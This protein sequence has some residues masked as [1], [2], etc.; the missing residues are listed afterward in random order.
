MSN[1]LVDGRDFKLGLFS[2]NCAGGL[3]VTK[4]PE[5]TGRA[6]SQRQSL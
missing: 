4:I 5:S 3:A 1:T 2:P 6:E